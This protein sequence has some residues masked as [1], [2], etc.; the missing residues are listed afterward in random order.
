MKKYLIAILGVLALAGAVMAPAC[1][2]TP[3]A[4][5]STGDAGGGE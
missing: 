3:A 2:G 4:D 5:G 1:G